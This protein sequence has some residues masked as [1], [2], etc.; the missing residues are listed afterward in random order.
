M[1][2]LD[3]IFGEGSEIIEE[4]YTETQS[5]IKRYM[6]RKNKKI[7]YVAQELGTTAGYFRKQLDPNQSDRMLSIDR[8]IAI[9]KLTMDK[10]ILDLIAKQFDMMLIS[11]NK[12][13]GEHCGINDISKLV[14]ISNMEDADVFR[15]VKV[16]L[17]DGKIDKEERDNILKE[18]DEADKAHAEL[19]EVIKNM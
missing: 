17:A 12:G 10:G 6:D 3:D 5:V 14:D 1:N 13:E 11:K 16:A 4:I 8:I 19:R 2:K 18:I 15:A 7:E 9:T